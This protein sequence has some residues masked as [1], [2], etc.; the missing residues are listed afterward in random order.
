M[1]LALLFA[2]LATACIDPVDPRWQLDHDHVIAA[3]ATPPRLRPLESATLDA[4]I[5]HAGGSVTVERPSAAIGP[6]EPAELAGLVTFRDGEWTVTAPD[7]ESLDR[8]RGS[9]G[10]APGTPL[11]VEI[12]MAFERAEQEPRYVKKTVWLGDAGDN[13][14]VPAL[15]I[16]GRRM[17]AEE[18]A[19]PMETDV[20]LS[21]AV[22]PEMRV[23]WLTSCGTLFQDDVATAFLRVLPDDNLDGELAVVVRSPDGGVAWN[24]WPVRAIPCCLRRRRSASRPAADPP[25]A[26][27]RP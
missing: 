18:L 11:P 17:N 13:P 22:D 16:D 6:E 20:Y 19:V 26:R 14:A 1:R 15:S 2:V 4:L 12:L 23:N 24:V 5:A 7:P 21:V 8:A 9:L 10:L 27:I 25:L 3:R